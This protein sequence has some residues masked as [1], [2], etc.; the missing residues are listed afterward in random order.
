M[1]QHKLLKWTLP[2][3]RAAEYSPMQVFCAET[4]ASR[5]FRDKP[6]VMATKVSCR[7]LEHGDRGMTANVQTT[8]A[9]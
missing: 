7:L 9:L 1:F 6:S 5:A 4:S 2:L 3:G 8:R